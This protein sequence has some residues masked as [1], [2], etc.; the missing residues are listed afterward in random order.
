MKK[1]VIIFIACILFG[2][3]DEL[4][5]ATHVKYEVTTTNGKWFGEYITKTGEKICTCHDVDHLKPSGW[6]HEFDVTQRPFTL[7]IDATTE[8]DFGSPGAPDVITK[9]FVDDE[10]VARDSSGWAPGVSSVDFIIK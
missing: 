5:R 8:H 2:C 1:T 9:I 10:L 3:K 7:H 6:T 4:D